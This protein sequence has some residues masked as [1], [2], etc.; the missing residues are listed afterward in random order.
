MLRNPLTGLRP[1]FVQRPLGGLARN[2]F[3]RSPQRQSCQLLMIFFPCAPVSVAAAPRIDG[4]GIFF[5]TYGPQCRRPLEGGKRLHSA[6]ALHHWRWE[7]LAGR[8]LYYRIP[9]PDG[10]HEQLM[11]VI[12]IANRCHVNGLNRKPVAS[13]SLGCCGNVRDSLAQIE[14]PIH[15]CHFTDTH[16]LAESRPHGRSGF[17]TV[18]AKEFPRSAFRSCTTLCSQT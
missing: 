3:Q 15:S 10:L 16:P 7:V 18:R 1:L 5:H 14:R 13:L 12:S 17:T 4:I 11:K 6:M 8:S 2:I 9:A